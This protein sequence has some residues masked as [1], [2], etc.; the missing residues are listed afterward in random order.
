M[1]TAIIA[2]VSQ[3][4]VIGS[5]GKLCWNI[6]EDLRFFKKTTLNSSIIMGRK[7]FD[8]IGFALPKRENIVISFQEN[9]KP[10]GVKVVNSVFD[11]II[12]ASNENIFI[13]GG[14]QIYRQSIDFVDFICLT[15][16]EKNFIGDAYFP[17]IDYDLWE[18]VNDNREF[19]STENTYF[20]TLLYRRI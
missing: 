8:S 19:S 15:L 9:Y 1:N 3:N 13:I 17:K 16:I 7:T 5:N 11:A 12:A 14:E 20:R 10:L 18:I 6:P 2:A 4:G